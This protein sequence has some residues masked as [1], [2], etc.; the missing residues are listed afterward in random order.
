VPLLDS[1]ERQGSAD[2]FMRARPSSNTIH[3]GPFQLDLKAGELSQD[4]R[5][6][7]LQEQPFQVLKMLLEHPGE[8]VTRDEIRR[9]LW[10]NDTIVEFDQSINAAVKK[11]RL[12][13]EDS[14]DDPR[15]VETVARRGYRLMVPVRPESAPSVATVAT[16]AIEAPPLS[17][18]AGNLIGK[19]VSHYRIL[20]VLG[21]GGMGVVYKAEDVKLGRPVALKFLPEEFASDARALERFEREARAASALDHPNICTIHEFGEHEGQP[22]IAMQFLEGMTLRESLAVYAG[23]SPS[24]EGNGTKPS[25]RV[26]ACPTDEL[27]DVAIQIA[28]GLEAAHQKDIIHRD[29]KPANIFITHRGEVKILDFGLAKVLA[30]EGDEQEHRNGARDAALPPVDLTRTGTAMGTASYMSPEQVRGEKL[31][32]RT[33]LFSFGLVLYEMST[34]EQAFPG[35]TA[36]AVCDAIL[37]RPLRPVRQLNPETPSGLEQIIA[38]SLQK[39]RDCRYQHAAEIYA[40]LQRLRRDRPARLSRWPI[41]AAIALSLLLV[42]GAVFWFGPHQA[43][44]PTEIKLRQLTASSAE[45]PI[46]YGA[47]SP[48]GKYLAYADL[49]GIHVMLVKTGEAQTFPQPEL[50]QGSRVDWQFFRWFPDGTRFLVNQNPPDERANGYSATIWTVSVLGGAPRKLREDAGV[51]SISPDGS[52][53]AFTTDT[54]SVWLMGPNGD[55]VRK[56]YDTGPNREDYNFTFSPD[57]KRL[58]YTEYPDGVLESRD[59]QGGLPVKMLSGVGDRLREYVWLPDGR[60]VYSLAEPNPNE[61]TCNLW[62]L[63]VDTHTGQPS[64]APQ[65]LTNWAGF[66]ADNLTATADGRQVVFQQWAGHASVYIADIEAN[67]MRITTPSRLTVNES[68]NIPSAWTADSKSVVFTSKFNGEAGIFHQRLDEDAPQPLVTGMADISDHT[69]LSPDGSWF[70]YNARVSPGASDQLMRVL[71]MGG[72]PQVVM[73]RDSDGVRCAR[74]PSALCAIAERGPATQLTFTAFDPL[75]GRGREIAKVSVSPESEWSW[76]LS[77]D[78]ARLAVLEGLSGQIHIVSLI[79]QAEREIKGKGMESTNFL[80]WTADGKALLVSRPTRRGFELLRLDLKGNSQVL[81]EQRGGLGTSALPSPDGRH[82]AIRGMSVTSNYWTI[83][84]F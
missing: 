32:P 54:H 35:E 24:T 78:G 17:P 43:S 45:D 83:E 41:A 10:P 51:E 70:L 64:G 25:V 13:L 29:I 50:F 31:D 28:A 67:G 79:G 77:P 80:D 36:P 1:G 48:D 19:K 38:R 39:D 62:E 57:G 2:H 75:R 20:H 30:G 15:Y 61:Q 55:Q 23:R 27:L 3:F 12:A 59:L 7:R 21:G 34:G 73:T 5:T 53:V 74:S 22:F 40:D 58:A 76:D 42:A 33:D 16:V 69:P 81:W 37:H 52:L 68:W 26:P 18:A 4:G 9:T 8:V 72:V 56:L 47:I 82:L 71:S 6:V 14:A 63:R 49:K 65:K 60:M 84:N 46:R 44:A 66:C 11:L